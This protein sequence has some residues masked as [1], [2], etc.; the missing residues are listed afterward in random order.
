[1]TLAD[2]TLVL[3]HELV[4][5]D[6]GRGRPRQVTLR[7]AVHCAYY[8]AFGVLC[9]EWATI[10]APEARPVA[11]RMLEHGRVKDACNTVAGSGNLA[12]GST[13]PANLRLAARLVPQLQARR[14][15][16]DYDTS[17]R[18]TRPQVVLL[19]GQADQV[20]TSLRS[21]RSACKPEL[22]L[23]LLQCAGAR[24]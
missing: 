13:C 20:M 4:R 21:S 12:G 14:H 6:P 10:F 19:L 2:D 24:R 7:K 23:F 3:G 22:H 17:A 9:E 8:A 1:L 11:A 16:A 5:L 15:D 18:F